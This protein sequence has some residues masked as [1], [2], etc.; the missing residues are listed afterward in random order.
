MCAVIEIGKF[1]VGLLLFE[2]VYLSER[3]VLIC[4]TLIVFAIY[5]SHESITWNEDVIQGFDFDLYKYLVYA[6]GFCCF[7]IASCVWICY[8]FLQIYW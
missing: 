4:S 6:V 8:D 1:T 3:S 2:L 5:A 7:W